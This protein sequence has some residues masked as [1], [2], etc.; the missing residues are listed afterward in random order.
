VAGHRAFTRG[1]VLPPD[2]IDLAAD[3]LSRMTVYFGR[4]ASTPSGP[5]PVWADATEALLQRS[6]SW[7]ANGGTRLNFRQERPGYQMFDRF[8][9]IHT[10]ALGALAVFG[11]LTLWD[12][13]QRTVTCLTQP[14]SRP[15]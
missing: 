11:P 6:P 8:K 2:F 1:S 5:L 3:H 10:G 13:T 14:T 15:N 9:V 4:L 7:H 12:R